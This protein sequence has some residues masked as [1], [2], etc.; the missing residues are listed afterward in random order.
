VESPYTLLCI[1]GICSVASGKD[2]IDPGDLCSL[3]SLGGG[4]SGFLQRGD[5]FQHIQ[6]L[7]TLLS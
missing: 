6:V 4:L 5:V 1:L 7:R 3:F 2:P